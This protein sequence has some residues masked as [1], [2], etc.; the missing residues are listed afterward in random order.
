MC[1]NLDLDEIPLLYDLVTLVRGIIGNHIISLDRSGMTD[2]F[3]LSAGAPGRS[4]GL[5]LIDLAM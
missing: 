1:A 4:A 2:S 5:A 3:Q